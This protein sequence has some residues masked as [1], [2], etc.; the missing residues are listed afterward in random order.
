MSD[1]YVLS[2]VRDVSVDEVSENQIVI[3]TWD[4]RFHLKN[5]TPGLR[6]AILVLSSDGATEDELARTALQLDGDSSIARF[7]FYMQMFSEHRI[8]L[9]SVQS[10]GFRLATLAPLSKYF[11]FLQKAINPA[12]EYELSQFAYLHKEKGELV[13]D[14]LSPTG[15]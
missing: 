5:L 14:L 6:R 13:L 11:Q 3:Q 2:L 4:R 15:R 1:N 9:H 8:M 12:A 7:Y 10:N